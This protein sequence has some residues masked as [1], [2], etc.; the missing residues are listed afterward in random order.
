IE[1]FYGQVPGYDVAVDFSRKAG[2]LGKMH[3]TMIREENKLENGG[4]GLPG[5]R[6]I[7]PVPGGSP[8]PRREGGSPEAPPPGGQ[9]ELPRPDGSPPT[10]DAPPPPAPDVDTGG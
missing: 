4:P 10:P 8:S 6:V 3:Q 2:P 1:Q 5:E 7:Q 9:D